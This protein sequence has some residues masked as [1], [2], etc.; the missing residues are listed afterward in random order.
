[1]NGEDLT[2]AHGAPLRLVVPGW[3]GDHWV[4]WLVRLN[5]AKEE[6]HG[7]FM[8]TG[9]RMPVSPVEPGAAVPP[10]QTRPA[11][12]FPV[13]SV[14]G[15]PADGAKVPRGPQEVVGVAFSG[16]APIAK[17]E[18]SLDGG[19]TWSPAKLE[20]EAGIGRWN[21]FR[22]AFGRSEAGPV[23]AMARATDR[24]GNVQPEKASWNP[25]GYFWNAWHAVT[26]EVE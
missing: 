18:V 5:V 10:S 25:S 9:Y 24:K 2:H 20:G 21:V 15:A 1:M 26:W 3:A 8:D 12:T 16:L 17:V 4:K 22:Y 11:T 6:A 13:K 23:H 14:I 7:F 19:K